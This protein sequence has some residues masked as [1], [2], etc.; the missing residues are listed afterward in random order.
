MT[1]DPTTT[2]ETLRPTQMAAMVADQSA[3]LER[4]G[5]TTEQ[6]AEHQT[7]ALR[8]LLKR[9]RED[10]PFH[11]RRLAGVDLSAVTPDDLSALPVMTKREMMAELDD[12]YTDRRLNSDLVED[13]LARTG[14]DPVP[15]LDEYLAFTSGG[16]SGV[17]GTFVYDTRAMRQLVGAFS[18]NLVARLRAMGGPAPGG[19]PIG[20]IGASNA[21]H[22][23]GA[24]PAL[25]AGGKLGFWYV[26]LPATQPLPELVAHLNDLQLPALAGF[27]SMLARLAQEQLAGRLQIA[28]NFL[29][30]TSEPVTPEIREII[31]RAFDAPLINTFA[32]TEGLVGT[33]LPDD[34]AIVFAC[35]GSIVEL[36]DEDNQPVPAG[37]P[38]AKALVTNLSNH[39]QPLIRYE[40]TDR[41]LRLPDSPHHGHLRVSVDGRSDDILHFDGVSV[42]PLSVRSVLGK[43][44]GITEYQVR[45]TARGID[46]DLITHTA[47]DVGDVRE[48]LVRALEE[49]GLKAPLVSVR[50]VPALRRSPAT[51][52]LSRFVPLRPGLRSPR[53]EAPSSSRR[54]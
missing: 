38:S 8:D 25:T 23:T 2:L 30:A 29:S 39:A 37:T 12:V 36:V 22:Q 35:D 34:D 28:P 31:R 26:G 6:L 54:P 19:L 44:P 13:I 49:A 48:R 4:A 27:P 3:H 15:I 45:Q 16:S 43:T 42:H 40:L 47:V 20:Y 9:A 17:R 24:A 11:A 51:G 21:V 1:S 52:K 18:R 5:W 10:S 7:T 50:P 33:S 46:V 14:H 41:F 32:S 53:E